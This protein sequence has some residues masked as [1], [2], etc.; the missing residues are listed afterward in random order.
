MDD[1]RVI[2]VGTHAEPMAA[3]GAYVQLVRQQ[4]TASDPVS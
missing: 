4:F 3:G 2:E 1:G